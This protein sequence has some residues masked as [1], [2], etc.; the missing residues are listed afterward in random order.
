MLY[1]FFELVIFIDSDAHKAT[2]F[3]ALQLPTSILFSRASV[4]HKQPRN[5]KTGT[6]FQV[7][8]SKV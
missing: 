4:A 2:R 3:L 6:H 8:S 7:T 1:F 5:L